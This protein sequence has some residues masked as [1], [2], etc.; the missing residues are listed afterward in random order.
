[1]PTIP[2]IFVKILPYFPQ[3]P[4]KLFLS[5]EFCLD[6][7]FL[8]FYIFFFTLSGDSR[9]G[10]QWRLSANALHVLP[11]SGLRIGV[12]PPRRRQDYQHLLDAS[13]EPLVSPG[14]PTPTHAFEGG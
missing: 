1:M 10:I 2:P 12:G 7:F 6:A 14:T 13:D 11:P 3:H 5:S 4:L 9:G 8:F